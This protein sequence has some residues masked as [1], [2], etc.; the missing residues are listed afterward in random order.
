MRNRAVCP[1]AVKSRGTSRRICVETLGYWL[2][3]TFWLAQLP[4]FPFWPRS[5]SS[6]R[7]QRVRIIAGARID[8]SFPFSPL[9][10]FGD[11]LSTP[12]PRLSVHP[13]PR[14]CRDRIVNAPERSEAD[15]AAQPRG[16]DGAEPR[17]ALGPC[18]D[19]ALGR[20]PKSA[21]VCRTAA[22]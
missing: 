10:V 20:P 19:M 13:R 2:Y 1:G 4:K 21:L 17:L 8:A 15:R 7:T 22:F 12:I 3:D 11:R 9:R 6:A 5:F 18:T 16:L 14:P